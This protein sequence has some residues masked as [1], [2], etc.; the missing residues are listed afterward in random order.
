MAN[1]EWTWAGSW[2]AVLVAINLLNL[3][4]CGV[5]FI[6]SCN[7]ADTGHAHYRKLMRS[8]GAIFI[9]VAMYRAVFVS[10]YLDQL[11]WFDTIANSSLLIRSL[12]IFAEISF[13]ALI[14]LALLQL[15]KEV[16]VRADGAA[17]RLPNFLLSK[18]PYVFFACIFIAQFFA[19]TATVNKVKVL[20][21][22]EETLWGIAF[23]SILP[24]LLTQLKRIYSYKR[25]T[26]WSELK[27]FRGF[28]VMMAAFTV[29][30]C[31]YSLCYHLPIEYWPSAIAQLQMDNPVPAFRSG[32]QAI[33]DAFFVV[34]VTRDLTTWGGVGFLIWYTGYFSLCGWMVLYLMNGP[35]RVKNSGA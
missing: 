30:Y 25:S 24:L 14:M 29:G 22:I 20:F 26:A 10:N 21:A 19:T 34:N 11:A 18:T 4:A 3:I 12:A 8:F 16:P 7:S 17:E 9:L 31:I 13:A 6:R 35:R 5:I 28:V 33:Q 32:V 1:S 27:L 2:W 23:L 15:N